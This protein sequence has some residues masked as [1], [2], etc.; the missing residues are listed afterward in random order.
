MRLIFTLLAAPLILVCGHVLAQ[1]GG[2]AGVTMRVVD[3]LSG[4]DAVVLE[5][6]AVPAASSEHTD[7]AERPAA[8]ERESEEASGR[9]ERDN[10]EGAERPVPQPPA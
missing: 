4:I 6:E 8:E 9:R 7:D 10:P 1:G 2:L 3:D 5:L